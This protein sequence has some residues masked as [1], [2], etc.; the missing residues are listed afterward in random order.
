VK[1]FVLMIGTQSKTENG[2]PLAEIK[3]CQ[4]N[5][6]PIDFLH[7]DNG[8]HKFLLLWCALHL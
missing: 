6:T 7:I 4:G 8:I 5:K 2:A 1:A 3:I